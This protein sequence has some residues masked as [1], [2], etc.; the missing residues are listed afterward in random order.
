MKT[1]SIGLGAE[2]AVAKLLESRGHQIL[3]QN[4][5][6]PVCEIDLISRQRKII[7]FTE[8]KYRHSA[9]QG[10][11][12]SYI[13]PSKLKRIKFAARIWLQQNNSDDDWRLQAA[14]VSGLDFENIELVEIT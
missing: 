13:T 7:Y 14:E 12:L 2:K 5:R 11:G 1:R 8:V 4:W 10:S 9:T 6:T 3:A